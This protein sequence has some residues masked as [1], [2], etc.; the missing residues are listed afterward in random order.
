MKHSFNNFLL[1][2]YYRPFP[3]LGAGGLVGKN[4]DKNPYL[5]RPYVLVE[6]RDN[7]QDR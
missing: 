5:Q 4:I 1:S 2:T 3:V 7:A 6:E